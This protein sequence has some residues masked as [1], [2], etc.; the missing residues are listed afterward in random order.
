ML[1]IKRS[2]DIRLKTMKGNTKRLVILAGANGVGKTTL[3]NELLKEFKLK[4]L[5]A[6]EIAKSISPGQ[7]DLTKVRIKAG[8][9]LLSQLNSLINQNKSFALESTLSGKYLVKVI[10][11]M[12]SKLYKISIIYLFVDNPDVA[13]DRIKIRVKKGGHSIPNEDVIRRF[14][15]S[16]KNF[17]NIYR[18]I[19]NEWTI[20]YNG[21]GKLLPVASGKD[22][23]CEVVEEEYFGIFMGDIENE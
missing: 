12:K 6:D 14:G 13:I 7:T 3:A 19:V 5:N 2:K 10:N 1:D 22:K 20:F 4:L 15:R 16:K 11:G 18:K 21:A 23:Y 8:K 9:L 17:W